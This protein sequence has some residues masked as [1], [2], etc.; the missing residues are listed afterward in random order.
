MEGAADSRSPP[1]SRDNKITMAKKDTEDKVD[2]VEVPTEDKKAR[3]ARWEA[4]LEKAEKENPLFKWQ[5]DNGDFDTIPD[6]FK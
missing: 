3:Q 5:K 1:S 2:A 6:S 4:F